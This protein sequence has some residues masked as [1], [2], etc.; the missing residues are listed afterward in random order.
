MWPEDSM[1]T[2]SGSSV[3]EKA[4]VDWTSRV[5]GRDRVKVER[6]PRLQTMD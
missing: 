2:M 3:L 6:L 1:E 4:K 5:S